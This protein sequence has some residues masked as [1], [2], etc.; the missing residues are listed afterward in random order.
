MKLAE[1]RAARS[2]AVQSKSG[3]WTAALWCLPWLLLAAVLWRWAWPM[4]LERACWVREWPFETGCADLPDAGVPGQSSAAY[5]QH[6]ERN[7]GDS[8]ALAWLTSAYWSEGDAR[9]GALL[10]WALQLAP[11]QSGVLALDTQAQ[12]QAGNW[13]AAAKALITLLERGQTQVTPDLLRLMTTQPTASAVLGQLSTDSVWLDR[14][15][16]TL[17]D[18]TPVI[19]LQPFITAGQ[20]LGLLKPATVF[21]LIERLKREGAW[22]DAYTLWVA[23]KGQLAS[24]L[25]NGSFDQTA[26]RRG[27]DWEWTA[28]PAAR[29][30]FRVDQVPAAPRP[31]SM[32]ELSL[33]GRGA[34]PTPLVSQAMVLTGERYRLRGQFMVERLL[35][36]EGLVWALR[37]AQGGE[38]WAQTAA[39]MEGQRDW[40]S[41]ELEFEPPPACGAAV[42]LQLEATAAWEA[43][44]GMVGT[45]Y[46]DDFT[47]ERLAQDDTPATH[48]KR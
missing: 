7:V 36:K 18:K 31:G 11:N 44:A 32:L 21:A 12:L 37:C 47:L 48:S 29:Q 39:I 20:E 27:F 46:F 10:P 4:Q 40:R 19:A 24:G 13:N 2:A 35:A 26:Q 15:L 45:I 25:Y 33:T 1:T 23:W 43:R 17:D 38:R 8:R 16:A 22:I 41:F 30:G 34:L 42:R 5:L 14:V 3:R 28:Q 6:L 9:A